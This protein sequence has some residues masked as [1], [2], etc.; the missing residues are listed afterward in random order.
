MHKVLP[1][2]LHVYHSV[3][4]VRH[5]KLPFSFAVEMLLLSNL[6]MI[7]ALYHR[8]L[9]VTHHHISLLTHF[10]TNDLDTL[11][12]IY[13]EEGVRPETV[14]VAVVWLCTLKNWP[15]FIFPF[16]KAIDFDMQKWKEKNLNV[17]QQILFWFALRRNNTKFGKMFPKCLDI[18]YSAMWTKS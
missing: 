17:C 11:V 3:K 7:Q 2:W 12:N 15:R 8:C 13:V 18:K 10:T 6:S 4:S 5:W 14:C 16:E 1:H 9:V